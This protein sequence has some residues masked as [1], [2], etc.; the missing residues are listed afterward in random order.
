M[1]AA[2]RPPHSMGCAARR[3]DYDAQV[4]RE[5]R[6]REWGPSR[7]IGGGCL[8]HSA[9]SRFTTVVMVGL[10]VVGCS[11]GGGSPAPAGASQPAQAS[12]PA[13][14][15]CTDPK[16]ASGT[17]LTFASYGGVYQKA[18]RDGWLAPYS[19]LTGVKFTES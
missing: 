5:G 19:K 15:V 6:S 18:Q 8:M 14:D 1:P 3:S 12:A 10:L 16:A 11:G 9:S 4:P 7:D 13:A 2:R 17:T